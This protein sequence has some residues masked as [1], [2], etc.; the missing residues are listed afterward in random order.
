MSPFS[1]HSGRF[2]DIGRAKFQIPAAARTAREKFS[3]DPSNPTVRSSRRLARMARML[4]LP[5]S[6]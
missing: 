6:L 1:N 2:I 5:P 3:D 4:H